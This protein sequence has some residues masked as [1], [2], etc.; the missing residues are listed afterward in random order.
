MGKIKKDFHFIWF[1]NELTT[2]TYLQFLS[3]VSVVKTQEPNSIN[4]FTDNGFKGKLWDKVKKYIKVHKINRPE[5]NSKGSDYSKFVAY[6]D[7]ARNLII[8]EYGGIY[9]DLDIVW[10]KSIDPI[11]NELESIGS[12]FP[13]YAIGE[14]GKNGCEGLNMGVIIG[15]KNNMFCDAYLQTYLQYDKLVKKP[16]DHIAI[17]ST[18]VPKQL[19]TQYPQLGQILPYNFF[20]WP[21]YH[22]TKNWFLAGDSHPELADG[23]KQNPY[24]GG[25]WSNEDLSESFAHHCFFLDNR[26]QD[27]NISINA[28]DSEK[29]EKDLKE[30]PSNPRAGQ[31]EYVVNKKVKD[32]IRKTDSQF[33]NLCKPLLEF[34]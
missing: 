16:S 32:F 24:G 9:C 4:L 29:R 11:L 14:Q 3:I 28:M 31:Y 27:N 7:I 5:F 13:V 1:S 30:D 15:E 33:A 8:K 21:L 26:L 10:K 34:L 23:P 2:M 12:S 20:H 17:Y 22:V 18:R 6:S 19:L 25:Y